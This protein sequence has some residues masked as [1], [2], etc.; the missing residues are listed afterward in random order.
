MNKILAF[1][2]SWNTFLLYIGGI[3]TLISATLLSIMIFFTAK[4][5]AFSYK[6]LKNLNKRN[7]EL[8]DKENKLR[9]LVINS[10]RGIQFIFRHMLGEMH[11]RDLIGG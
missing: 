3:P 8:I 7:K 9:E 6:Q 5:K 10:P 11:Y 1:L 4:N 2:P